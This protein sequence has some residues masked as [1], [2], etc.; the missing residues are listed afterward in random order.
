[1]AIREEKLKR[2]PRR[3]HY[4]NE[5]PVKRS[6]KVDE[7]KVG[8]DGIGGT[9]VQ[10]RYTLLRENG[11]EEKVI[12]EEIADK[13]HPLDILF[14][15]DQYE[16]E[17][18]NNKEARRALKGISKAGIQLFER[19]AFFQTLIYASTMIM[20]ITKRSISEHQRQKFP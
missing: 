2:G 14:M 12:D 19:M 3:I 6:S 18:K 13:L 7:V 9:Y 1:M 20:C 11:E 15:K 5:N 16:K 8:I 17:R 4:T 10:N